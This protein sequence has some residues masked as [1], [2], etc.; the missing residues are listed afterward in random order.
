MTLKGYVTKI[1]TLQST[2]WIVM[3]KIEGNVSIVMGQGPTKEEAYED[4][5][6]TTLILFVKDYNFKSYF[7][8]KLL[9]KS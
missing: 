1:E 3:L 6:Q 8:E 9:K 4:L 5:F 2:P 7:E